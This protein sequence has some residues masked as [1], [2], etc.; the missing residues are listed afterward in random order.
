MSHF[1]SKGGIKVPGATGLTDVHAL[2]G[3]A[4][5]QPRSAGFLSR[6]FCAL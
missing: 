3:T 1:F 6:L 2:H 5:V 4:R